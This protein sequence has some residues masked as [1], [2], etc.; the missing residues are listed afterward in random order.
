MF[1]PNP[2]EDIWV[3]QHW[4]PKCGT[5]QMVWPDKKKVLI[6]FHGSPELVDLDQCFVDDRECYAAAASK[7]QR[8]AMEAM[9]QASEYS[10]KACGRQEPEAA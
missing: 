1:N 2:G 7:K 3:N 8:E 9:K 6:E 4:G 5:F 10:A